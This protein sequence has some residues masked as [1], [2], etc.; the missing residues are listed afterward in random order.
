MAQSR[1]N[2]LLLEGLTEAKVCDL[3]A[4]VVC[5]E[6][7]VQPQISV[8]DAS[9]MK[10]IDSREYLLEETVLQSLAMRIL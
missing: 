4:A 3:D 1:V 8:G 5:E 7:V 2:P 6:D 10:V 9:G